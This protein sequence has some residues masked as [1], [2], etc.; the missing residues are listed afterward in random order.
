[1]LLL[2]AFTFSS[3]QVS[4]LQQLASTG[5]GVAATSPPSTTSAVTGSRVELRDELL[6][7]LPNEDNARPV[8]LEGRA[9]E[10]LEALELLESVPASS[11]FLQFGL[12]GTWSLRGTVASTE[13]REVAASGLPTVP[14]GAPD[15]ELLS[16]GATYGSDGDDG[17]QAGA[18]SATCEFRVV[19]DDLV[20][21][22]EV[23]LTAGLDPD[24]SDTIFVKTNGRKLQMPR[25]PAICDVRAMM[26]SLHAQLPAEF[27]GD[28]GV[29]IGL[30]TTYLDET[31]RITRCTTRTLA[32]SCAV[33]L[34]VPTD[35]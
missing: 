12:R 32:G 8:V 1:M 34:R 21:A 25:A 27:L 7:L 11:A 15:V 4:P 30:Q 17:T 9:L 5:A 16:A 31:L 26:E 2:S 3:V 29:R 24:R 13:L 33:H 28:E 19:E 20:G 18:T 22:L 35:V 14:E 6:S 23:D 10:V